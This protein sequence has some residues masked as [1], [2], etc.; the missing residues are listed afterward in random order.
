MFIHVL[1]LSS[2]GK[3]EGIPYVEIIVAY[4]VLGCTIYYGQY[5]SG[6]YILGV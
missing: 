2:L 6:T 3:G 1:N 4:G 5:W